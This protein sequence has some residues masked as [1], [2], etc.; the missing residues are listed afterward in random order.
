MRQFA[1]YRDC[2]YVIL[3]AAVALQQCGGYACVWSPCADQIV[4][5]EAASIMMQKAWPSVE[6]P[7]RSKLGAPHTLCTKPFSS[8]FFRGAERMTLAWER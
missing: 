6:L 4:R 5:R 3:M 8:I 2:D 7:G 1:G